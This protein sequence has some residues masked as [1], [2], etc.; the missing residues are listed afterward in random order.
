M[1]ER[2]LTIGFIGTGVMGK[3]MAHNL[4]RSGYRVHVYSRTKSKAEDLL[5]EGA[6]WHD[7]PGELV[8]Q[9]NV[10]ISMVG[11]P[12][13]VEEIYL[14]SDGII[15]TANAGTIFIDMTTSSPNLSKQ[16]E[17]EAKKQG[18]YSLDAPVSGGDI[19]ARSGTLSI[20]VGGDSEVFEK[21][22]PIFSAL[23]T[24]V[25]HQGPAGAGQHTKICNQIAIASTM[26]G[27]CESIKYAERSGLDPNTVLKSIESGSAGSWSLSNLGPRII[28]EN[29]EPGFYVKH[30]IKD[31]GIA[32]QSAE[33]MGLKLYGLELAK[34][35]YSD[36]ANKGEENSGTHALFK[37]YE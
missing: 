8:T 6:T 36:L 4:L 10:L 20:M 28:S 18:C 27:V 12:K 7:S 13:D 1:K 15:Q 32:I 19:G 3:S 11:Y 31:M 16:I 9:C 33:E 5:N 23:G 17:A 14:G 34:A 2:D 35:L 30:F 21:V 26:M 25:V 24:N 22:E 37:L 29:F